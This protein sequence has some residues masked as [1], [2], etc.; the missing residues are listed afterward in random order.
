MR[1][2]CRGFTLLEVLIALAIFATAGAAILQ[3]SGSH[4]R[5]IAQL[6]ELTLASMVA[7]N[8]LQLAQIN[9]SWP[10]RELEQGEVRLGERDW[11]WQLRA[12]VVPDQD[13]RELVVTVRAAE[14]PEQ[15]VY[16]LK[17]YVGRPD[18]AN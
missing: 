14:A 18:A 1:K 5:A 17:T 13:L 12:N 7:N 9:R 6:E 16:Q 11:Q 3:A 10:P 15:I 2:I 8:Q 4:L